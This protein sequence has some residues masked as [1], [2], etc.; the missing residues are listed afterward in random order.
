MVS[1]YNCVT[2][3]LT[4]LMEEKIGKLTVIEVG[5]IFKSL[6]PT[7]YVWRISYQKRSTNAQI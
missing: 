1:S 7:V 2:I 5:V 3:P 6:A 4:G